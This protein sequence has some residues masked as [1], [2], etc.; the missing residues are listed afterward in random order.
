MNNG[1]DGVPLYE[2][3]RRLG[4]PKP[5]LLGRINMQK[6]QGFK[7]KGRVYL[8]SKEVARLERIK[9][10]TVTVT[11]AIEIVGMVRSAIHY[12][13]RRGLVRATNELPGWRVY[14]EDLEQYPVGWLTPSEVA[15]ELKVLPDTVIRRIKAGK[16]EGKQWHGRWYINPQELKK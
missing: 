2:A 9:A 15:Y 6:I 12:W 5:A 14:R 10:E 8:S 3:A 4:T 1:T 13:I 7:Y 16:L 11:E